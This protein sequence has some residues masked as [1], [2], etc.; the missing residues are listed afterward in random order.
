MIKGKQVLLCLVLNACI[1]RNVSR[2]PKQPKTSRKRRQNT[3][4]GV[5]RRSLREYSSLIGFAHEVNLAAVEFPFLANTQTPIIVICPHCIVHTRKSLA[6]VGLLVRSDASTW[7]P[8]LGILRLVRTQAR[9]LRNRTSTRARSMIPT[10]QLKQAQ[11]TRLRRT[12]G[13]KRL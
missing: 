12:R 7:H 8:L 9:F 11:N 10:K 6:P 1:Y 3:H 2:T 5:R 13:S 4:T